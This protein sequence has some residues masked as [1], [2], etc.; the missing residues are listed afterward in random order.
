MAYAQ[1][2]NTQAG[3]RQATDPAHGNLRRFKGG[4]V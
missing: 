2:L 4:S 1:A 3:N